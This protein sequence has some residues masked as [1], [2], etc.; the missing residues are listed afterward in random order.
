MNELDSLARYGSSSHHLNSNQIGSHGFTEVVLSGSAGPGADVTR[1]GLIQERAQL[2]IQYLEQEFAHRNN[3][4]RAL[5]ARGSLMDSIAYRN[6]IN[7][8]RTMD[9]TNDD[10]ILTCCHH[11]CKESMDKNQLRNLDTNG[12]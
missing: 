5:T 2:A 12:G 4:L 6:E 8:G 11:F 1:P 7:G 3:R 9:Q 10:V